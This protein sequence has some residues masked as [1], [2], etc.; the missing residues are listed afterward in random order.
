V[1][2]KQ[3]TEEDK[4]ASTE[5]N[6]CLR[7]TKILIIDDEPDITL[8][9]RKALMNNGFEDVETANDP[10]LVLKNFKKG[11]YHLL[12]ID[13]VMS[14][15][16]GFSLYEEVKK[17]DNKVKVCFMT[18]FGI[19]YQALRDLF[20]AATT[21]DDTGCFIRKPVNTDDMVKHVKRELGRE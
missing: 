2:E 5:Y 15:M 1:I 16:D 17:I 4:D 7:K 14:Q 19:N 9:F 3:G 8:L 18:A 13:V 6:N 10:R 11:S 12:I 21:T 20:P